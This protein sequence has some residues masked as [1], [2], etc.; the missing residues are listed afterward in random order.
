MQTME[1]EITCNYRC[2]R[3]DTQGHKVGQEGSFKA[4]GR[5]N[6]YMGS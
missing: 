3:G 1:C 4:P 2:L 5:E 6:A